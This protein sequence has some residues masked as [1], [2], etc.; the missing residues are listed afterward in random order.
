MRY[1]KFP[2]SV[3]VSAICLVL[4]NAVSP[5]ALAQS[6]AGSVSGVVSDGAGAVIPA[7]EVKLL[8]TATGVARPTVTNETGY[9]I[10]TG[11]QPALYELTVSA[12]G[13]KAAVRKGVQLQVGQ[14]LRSDLQLEV[15]D[16]VQ[17]VEIQSAAPLLESISTKIGTA[18]ETKQV[19][20]LPLNGRQFGQLI[21][22]T[23]GALPIALGQSTAFKVQL[24]AGSYSPVINGQRSRYNN[25][26][27]D[28]VENND[29]MFNSYA[30]NPS[31]DAI[32]EFSVQSRGGVTEQ[33]RSMGSDIVVVTRSGTNQYRGSVFEFLRNTKLDARNFFDPARP[34]FKQNQFGGTFGGPL[35]LPKYNGHDRTFFFGYYEGFRSVRSSN[36]FATVPTAAMAGGDFTEAGQPIIYD[37]L[38]T[39]ADAT[40]PG[41]STRAVLPRQPPAHRTHQSTGAE[42]P[43]DRVSGSERGRD[44]PQLHQYRSKAAEE[45]PSLDP[46]RSQDLRQ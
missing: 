3:A 29:P 25:F 41:G 30:M 5:L 2:Q 35:R 9:F 19:T 43:Q 28:G 22:L 6:G 1:P 7:A 34:T 31:V 11:L 39:R 18:V 38:T 32:Q 12:R 16:L 21:L 42:S 13:F 4:A 15:G 20:E 17:T 33:G 45:R 8:N 24:G 40:V 44:Y 36:S 10:F 37:I 27:L 26:T 14:A 23:P 46:D